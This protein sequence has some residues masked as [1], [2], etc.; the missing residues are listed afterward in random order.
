MKQSALLSLTAFAF[1]AAPGVFTLQSSD[2]YPL[3]AALRQYV[4]EQKSNQVIPLLVRASFHDI[5]D[6]DAGQAGGQGCLV[7]QPVLNFPQNG[8]LS[9]TINNLFNFVNL[10]FPNNKFTAG[11]VISLA[12]KVSAEMAFG[13][14]VAWSFGR[15]VCNTANTEQPEAP[16]G[17]ITTMSQLSPF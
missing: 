2:F 10:N 5:A 14:P 15:S 3:H 16:G 11:D 17:N 12:G 6:F 1:A 9:S 8:G 13:A 7:S 4:K